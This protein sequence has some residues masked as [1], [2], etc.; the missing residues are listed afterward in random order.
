[1]N[2]AN[3][4]IKRNDPFKI[5]CTTQ[6]V[7][8]NFRADKCIDRGIEGALWDDRHIEGINRHV[9]GSII[10][11]VVVSDVRSTGVISPFAVRQFGTGLNLR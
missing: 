1:M 10:F 2:K 4:D 6:L 5:C 7:A 8:L 3:L 11:V 9:T